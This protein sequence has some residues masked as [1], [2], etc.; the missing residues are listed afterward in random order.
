MVTLGAHQTPFH[1]INLEKVVAPVVG[2]GVEEA[3]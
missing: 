1:K 3:S 2:G